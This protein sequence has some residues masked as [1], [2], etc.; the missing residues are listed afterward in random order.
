M[1]YTPMYSRQRADFVAA[2]EAEVQPLVDAAETARDETE[3]MLAAGNLIP[4]ADDTLLL[5][6]RD[7]GGFYGMTVDLL[8]GL[9]FGDVNLKS[10]GLRTDEFHLIEDGSGGF[11]VRDESGYY[12]VSVGAGEFSGDTSALVARLV[13]LESGDNASAAPPPMPRSEVFTHRGT[14]L[15]SIAPENSR[16]ALVYSAKAGFRF[17]ETDARLTSDGVWVV[18]HDESLNRTCKLASGYATISGT[19]NVAD[20][21][22]ATLRADYV[23]AS[24][25]PAQRRPVPTVAE[26]A[27]DCR[28]LGIFPVFEI[29]PSGA[30][31]AQVAALHSLL[32]GILGEDGFGLDSFHFA[33]L[34]YVRTL[35]AVTPL[36]YVHS[37]S[38]IDDG[39][40]ATRAAAV[41]AKAPAS[42]WLYDTISPA[43]IAAARAEGL[44]IG[45][46]TPPA[47]LSNTIFRYGV[48]EI[49]SDEM[50]PRLTNQKVVWRSYGAPNWDDWDHTGTET[51]GDLVLVAGDTVVLA[52]PS[53]ASVGFG[54]YYLQGEYS[55]AIS[56]TGT[57]IG[58]NALTSTSGDYER[59]DFSRL[60]VEGAPAIT[61]TAGT[62]G[63]RLHG[64]RVAVASFD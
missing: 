35:S 24:P 17:N 43:I 46:A 53:A 4:Q 61:I 1:T 38:T 59:F 9:S 57:G 40:A 20:V 45:Y 5:A 41:K 2:V 29:K 27:A 42:L 18:M 51:D 15:S 7:A 58:T 60:L 62:G 52:A 44:P 12:A 54:A 10:D 26:Y 33:K 13:A 11:F 23:L 49:V 56:I 6:T 39:T 25:K 21:S 28:D 50:P 14:F 31:D 3:T 34:D 47:S 64:L 55:G 36:Y 48:D 32:R 22:A 30:S 16:D 63:A 19:V 8:A 37:S